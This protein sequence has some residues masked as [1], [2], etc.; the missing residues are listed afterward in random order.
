MAFDAEMNRVYI[1]TGNGAPW[2]RKI[3][4]PGGGDNLFLCSI[5]ALDADTRPLSLALP[6]QSRRDLGTL[7]P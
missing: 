6:S 4:S 5:V 3:R 2:N 1:G 7:P